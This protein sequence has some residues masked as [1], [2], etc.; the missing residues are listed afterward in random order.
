MSYKEVQEFY[1]KQ[2][3]TLSKD[4][5]LIQD[6]IQVAPQNVAL[7]QQE[8]KELSKNVSMSQ[9]KVEASSEPPVKPDRPRS[10]L[11]QKAPALIVGS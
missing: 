2:M 9:E 11:K 5:A 8:M 3:N 6:R 7:L 1:Q 10:M 4:V